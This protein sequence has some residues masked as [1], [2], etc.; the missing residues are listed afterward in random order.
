MEITKK[1]ETMIREIA[2]DFDVCIRLMNEKINLFWCGTY[3]IHIDRVQRQLLHIERIIRRK[4]YDLCEYYNI[5]TFSNI[6]G[7]I[8]KQRLDLINL[9]LNEHFVHIFDGSKLDNISFDDFYDYK[10]DIIYIIKYKL[11]QKDTDY[12]LINIEYN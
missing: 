11:G 7:Y 12:K 4:F 3:K 2:G 6:L 9:I 8:Y 1:S 10:C 5:P